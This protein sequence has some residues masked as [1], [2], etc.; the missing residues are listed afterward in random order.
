M[1]LRGRRGHVASGNLIGW[2]NL[3]D[4]ERKEVYLEPAPGESGHW[5]RR[6]AG[7]GS[8]GEMNKKRDEMLSNKEKTSGSSRVVGREDGRGEGNGSRNAP[9]DR[10]DL[11]EAGGVPSTRDLDAERAQFRRETEALHAEEQREALR[12]LLSWSFRKGAATDRLVKSVDDVLVRSYQELFRDFAWRRWRE[13]ARRGILEREEFHEKYGKWVR[14]AEDYARR[15]A[16]RKAPGS[17]SD[18]ENEDARPPETDGGPDQWT[19]QYA[20]PLHTRDSSSIPVPII[21]TPAE[22]KAHLLETKASEQ[23]RRPDYQ[24][25]IKV[26]KTKDSVL[27]PRHEASVAGATAR[28]ENENEISAFFEVTT[29]Q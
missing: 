4:K 28:R 10:L 9:V 12:S 16:A 29:P 25:C 24:I 26:A 19:V 13:I 3:A 8:S 7:G 5:D 15:K 14:K 2:A 6:P 20:N 18:D 23:K 11:L 21:V 22:K 27:G 17:A 1:E